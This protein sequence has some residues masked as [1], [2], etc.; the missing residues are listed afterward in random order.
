MLPGPRPAH[1]PTIS[2]K[3]ENACQVFCTIVYCRVTHGMG[4]GGVGRGDLR[5]KSGNHVFQTLPLL[6]VVDGG[7]LATSTTPLDAGTVLREKVGHCLVFERV[8]SI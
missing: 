6:P 8:T 3:P 5:Q 4:W 7:D 2:E 1:C